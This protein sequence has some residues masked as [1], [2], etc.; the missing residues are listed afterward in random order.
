MEAKNPNYQEAVQEMFRCAA[1]VNGV[2]IRLLGCGP[3]WCETELAIMPRHYQHHDFV[4]AGVQATI[5]DHTAG[6]AATTLICDTEVVLSAQ[7]NMSLLNTARGERLRCRSQVLKAGRVLIVVESEVFA[8][9][10]MNER[11]VSKATV[12]LAVVAGPERPVEEAS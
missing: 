10:G 11:L 2:G 8:G 12:T 1:F 3:G 9:K 6:A 5:A 7:F 4:H